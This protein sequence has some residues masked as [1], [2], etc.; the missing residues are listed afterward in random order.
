[1]HFAAIAYN[2]T[3]QIKYSASKVVILRSF[4]LGT[5]RR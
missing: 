3:Y 4:A 5:V 2:Y 1:M